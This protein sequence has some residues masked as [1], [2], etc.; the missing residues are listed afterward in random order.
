MVWVQ[1]MLDRTGADF[2]SASEACSEGSTGAVKAANPVPLEDFIVCSPSLRA[3]VAVSSRKVV[4][5]FPEQLWPELV[6]I[7]QHDRAFA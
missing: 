6:P 7:L 4:W 5:L 3:L 1:P 2:G